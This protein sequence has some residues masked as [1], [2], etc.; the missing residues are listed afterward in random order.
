MYIPGLAQTALSNSP[1]FV[2]YLASK[3]VRHSLAPFY[4]SLTTMAI[5]EVTTNTA[6]N[7][8]DTSLQKACLGRHIKNARWWEN[9][10]QEQAKVGSINGLCLTAKEIA[11]IQPNKSLQLHYGLR[12]PWYRSLGNTSRSS[13]YAL[14]NP[15]SDKMSS[16]IFV[17]NWRRHTGRGSLEI[18]VT[19]VPSHYALDQSQQRLS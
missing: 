9:H 3:P 14:I 10:S 18:R 16:M 8:R 13:I 12:C 5:L 17:I 15:V 1:H 2:F 4:S 11:A 6:C 7:A 19:I